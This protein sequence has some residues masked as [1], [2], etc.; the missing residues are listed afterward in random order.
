MRLLHTFRFHY[1]IKTLAAGFS[2]TTPPQNYFS[3]ILGPPIFWKFKRMTNCFSLAK[4]MGNNL[5]STLSFWKKGDPQTCKTSIMLQKINILSQNKYNS[6]VNKTCFSYSK[7]PKK[8][9][10]TLCL[11]NCW[12]TSQEYIVCKYVSKICVQN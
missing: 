10:S 6:S 8:I 4:R 1:V 11:Q 2:T 9:S 7:W 12:K 5:S 3:E